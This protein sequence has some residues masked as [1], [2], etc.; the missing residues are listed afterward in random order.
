MTEVLAAFNKGKIADVVVLRISVFV[1]DM[2]PVRDRP[3]VVFPHD[4]M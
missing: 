3:V 2:P 4:S 1:V